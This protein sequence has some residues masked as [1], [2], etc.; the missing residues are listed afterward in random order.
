ML[1][2]AV[3][4]VGTPCTEA[5]VLDMAVPGSSPVP[6]NLCH[7]S[8]LICL[9]L[10]ILSAVDKGHFGHK[11]IEMLI[12]LHIVFTPN[13]VTLTKK[14]TYDTVRKSNVKLAQQLGV[15]RILDT[16]MNLSLQLV[17]YSGGLPMKVSLYAT[18]GYIYILCANC[19]IYIVQMSINSILL[20]IKYKLNYLIIFT[21]PKRKNITLASM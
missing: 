10:Q 16:K 2:V 19:W 3:V 12:M 5:L 15:E 4:R 18:T 1:R 20:H 7:M 21:L 11:N 9:P 14:N 13:P 17:N 8:S 6:A